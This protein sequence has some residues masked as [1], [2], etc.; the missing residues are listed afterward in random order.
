VLTGRYIFGSLTCV[1]GLRRYGIGGQPIFAGRGSHTM[2]WAGFATSYPTIMSGSY[3]LLDAMETTGTLLLNAGALTTDG[4]SLTCGNGILAQ[5]SSCQFDL[6]IS[7]STVTI[8]APGSAYTWKTRATTFSL[9]ATGSTLVFGAVATTSP[10][11]MGAYT[12]ND[13]VFTP[14][15]TGIATL[16]GDFTFADMSMASAGSATIKFTGGSS[17]TMTGDTFLAGTD[18]ALVTITSSDTSQYTLTKSSAGYVSSDYL[19]IDHCT[20][21]PAATSWYAGANSVDGGHNGTPTWTFAAPP[22]GRARMRRYHDRLYA[23]GLNPGV[24]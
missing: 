1:S 10:I 3:T 6:D 18:G 7:G 11:A 24:M 14:H 22:S 23:P 4:Y 13:I 5:A 16:S 15:P 9:T 2:L 20:V 12:Y 17:V 21:S 19:S 8:T